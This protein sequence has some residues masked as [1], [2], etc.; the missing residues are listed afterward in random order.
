MKILVTGGAGF[1]GSHIV[2]QL[3]F[4]GYHVVVIDD[5]SKGQAEYVNEDAIFYHMSVLDPDLEAVFIHEKPDVVIHHAAQID[6]QRSLS[7]PIHDLHVNVEGTVRLLELCRH[8]NVQKFIYASSAAVY[9][10]PQYL[11][12]DEAHP[13]QPM[14]SYGISKFTP[15][16]YI[17][18]YAELYGLRYTILRYAN[19]YGTRQDPKGEGGVVS[20]FVDKL[21]KGEKPVIYGDGEQTRDF[22]YGEDVAAANV[23]ALHRG[24]NEVLNI[25]TGVPTSVNELLRVLNELNETD[26]LPEYHPERPGDIRH[27]YLKNDKALQMLGWQPKVSL[28]EGLAKTLDYYRNKL[29]QTQNRR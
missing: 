24:D 18:V 21:L 14:S 4:N 19:V 10:N 16:Q 22:I 29:Y 6:V 9:G 5:L 13:I 20:I 2:D 28:R 11:G 8:C 7:D 23:A 12:I 1:I 27:S 25:S 17:R 15:E 3:L 26:I